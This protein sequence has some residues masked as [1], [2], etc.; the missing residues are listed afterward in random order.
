MKKILCL[1][2]CMF[3]V[4]SLVSCKQESGSNPS[5]SI[6]IVYYAKLGQINE[7]NYILGG[8]VQD[9][10]DLLNETTDDHGEP[11]YFDFESGDYTVMT[12]GQI[13]VCYKTDDEEGGITHIVKYG[14][15]YGFTVGAVSTQ[16]RDI[17]RDV[18]ESEATER[19]SKDG[20]LFF[21]PSGADMTVLE[22]KNIA[23]TNIL[24]VFQE[25]ALSATVISKA[26]K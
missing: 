26:L 24:F 6:D 4:F 21:L 18:F 13:C 11:N 3:F 19:S 10:R 15:A 12:D 16:I 9:A 14:D 5:H 20:E 17:M 22:Y 23:D 8:N 7:L 25:H 2:L 1:I